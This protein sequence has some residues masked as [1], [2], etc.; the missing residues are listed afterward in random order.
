MAGRYHE[1]EIEIVGQRGRCPNGHR[2]GQRWRV[3]RHTPAGLC[4]GAFSSLLPYLTTL[5]FG[6]AFPLGEGR[7]GGHLLLPGP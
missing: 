3:G 5:R 6:G 7:R 1:V 2:V 4:I